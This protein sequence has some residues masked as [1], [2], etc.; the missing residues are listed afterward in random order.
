MLSVPTPGKQ[1]DLGQPLLKIL[2]PD[3]TG[4]EQ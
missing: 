3:Y 1:N 2:K 4:S